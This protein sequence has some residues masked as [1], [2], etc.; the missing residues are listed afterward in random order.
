MQCRSTAAAMLSAVF[1]CAG[2]VSYAQESVDIVP[3]Y[4]NFVASR[5]AASKCNALDEAS[6]QAFIS[7]LSVVSAQATQ[8]LEAR[9]PS[10]PKADVVR[11]MKAMNEEARDE[12]YAMIAKRGCSSPEV[13]RLVQLYKTHAEVKP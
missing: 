5:A 10:M 6:E 1:V 13:Q 11:Q 8:A 7:N 4:R 3:I 12:A 9:N 2:V